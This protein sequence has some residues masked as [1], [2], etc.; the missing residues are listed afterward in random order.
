MLITSTL[1]QR[2][3]AVHRTNLKKHWDSRRQPTTLLAQ[4]DSSVGGKNGISTAYGKNTVGTFYQPRLVLADVST[5]DSL[6]EREMQAGYAE[7]VKYGLINDAAFFTWCQTHGDKLLRGDRAAQIEAVS[8]S[9][10]YKAAIVIADEHE[11]G[12]RALLNLGHT[13][14]H[15]L[16]AITGYSHLI[17]HG[18]AVS[19]GM[20][21]A[22]RLSADLGLC[23]AA[24]ARAV[25]EHLQAVGLP[26]KPPAFAYDIERLMALMAQDKKAEHG[27]LTLIL[28]RG[29]GQAFVNPNT[30]PTP[31]RASWQTL[32]G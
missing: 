22:F 4:V 13:F 18:E 5:L 12:V 11:T 9:C 25:R 15:A 31:V 10:A 32:L 26:I 8:R 23:P 7:V 29:I 2:L 28:A 6:P 21:M 17:L 27:K 19:I 1:L 30:N 20:A 16:E 24:D 14:G 3:S